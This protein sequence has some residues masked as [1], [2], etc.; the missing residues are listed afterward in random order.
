[1]SI[2][3]EIEDLKKSAAKSLEKAEEI[4]QQAIDQ[5]LEERKQSLAH[6]D[7]QLARLGYGQ[8][9]ATLGKKRGRPKKEQPI[10][11][12]PIE[13]DHSENSQPAS[14]SLHSESASSK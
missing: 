4:R 1:M 9:K 13:P 2:W 14:I 10:P 5:L 7:E 11:S 6:F 12:E 8:E 3:S